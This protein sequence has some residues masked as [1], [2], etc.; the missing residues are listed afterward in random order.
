MNAIR[1]M[2][3]LLLLVVVTCS[4]PLVHAQQKPQP[5]KD[6]PNK[7]IRMLC[8]TTPGS[9]SDIINR[10]LAQRLSER[11]GYPVVV[12]NRPGAAGAI[13]L[14]MLAGATPDGY[15]LSVTSMSAMT[16]WMTQRKALLNVRAYTPIVELTSL[17]YLVV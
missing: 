1:S 8:G 13:A 5:V 2:L 12:E 16:G 9:G 7:T 3:R 6:Y 15:T 11:F 17:P 14:D 10:M 4:L